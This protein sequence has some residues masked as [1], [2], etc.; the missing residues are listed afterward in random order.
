MRV[1]DLGFWLQGFG[2][3]GFLEGLACAEV[4][5][6]LVDLYEASSSLVS[7]TMAISHGPVTWKGVDDVRPVLPPVDKSVSTLLTWTFANELSFPVPP[8]TL[9]PLRSPRIRPIRIP[10]HS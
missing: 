8:W 2:F 4:R 5:G 9:H 7:A 10:P 6:L 1:K 3:C